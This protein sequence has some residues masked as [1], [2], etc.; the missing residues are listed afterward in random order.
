MAPIRSYTFST[1]IIGAV[2]VR[3]ILELVLRIWDFINAPN[4]PGVI[5]KANPDKKTVIFFINDIFISQFLSKKFHFTKTGTQLTVTRKR[6]N[7]K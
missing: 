1:S 5:S 2:F 4:L 3:G 6:I 7:G